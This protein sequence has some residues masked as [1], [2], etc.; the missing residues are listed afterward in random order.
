MKGLLVR[1]GIDST[2]GKWNAPMRHSSGEFAFVTITDELS[3]RQG[4]DRYYDEYTPVVKRFGKE[5]PRHLVGK[6][7]HLDPDFQNLTYGDRGQRG[8]R[9]VSTVNNGDFLAFFASFRPVDNYL[10]DLAYCLIGLYMIEEIVPAL[11]VPQLRWAENAHTRCV[12]GH[13]DI[14]VRA[15]PGLSGRLRKC[16]PIGEW[17]GRAYR[18]RN[19]L[20]GLWGGLDIKNGYIQR[21]VRLPAFLNGPRFY[22]WFQ[23]QKPELLAENNPV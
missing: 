20:L 3:L 11:S 23:A 21:S 16:I 18:V 1:V 10:R 19:D 9:I 17:R 7:T 4:M 14:V 12:P 6:P 22:D 8:S 5:L 2:D 15:R 13:S